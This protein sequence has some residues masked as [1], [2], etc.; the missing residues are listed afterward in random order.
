MEDTRTEHVYPAVLY[1]KTNKCTMSENNKNRNTTSD[2]VH[3]VVEPFSGVICMS[4][5]RTLPDFM[6]KHLLFQEET[7]VY[8]KL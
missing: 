5:H 1:K 4:D 3:K 2:N 6:K 7:L 8:R